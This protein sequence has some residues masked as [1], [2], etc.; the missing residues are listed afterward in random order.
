LAGSK[1]HY[2]S[3]VSLLAAFRRGYAKTART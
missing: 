2:M 1:H 3:N